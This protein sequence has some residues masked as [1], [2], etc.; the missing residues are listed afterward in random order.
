MRTLSD[1][2]KKRTSRYCLSQMTNWTKSQN[3]NFGRRLKST[4]CFL[5]LLC[6]QID[7]TFDNNFSKSAKHVLLLFAGRSETWS[8]APSTAA[9][10]AATD[11]RR[12]SF[13]RYVVLHARSAARASRSAA[14][15]PGGKVAPPL[16]HNSR[17]TAHGFFP[18][19][20]AYL[21]VCK[22]TV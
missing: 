10:T 15:L 2:Q 20:D 17:E 21:G 9:E 5:T 7:Q 13:D 22:S 11:A 19:E 4:Q 14:D 16:R 18:K 8:E 6:H 3:N 1:R 12:R